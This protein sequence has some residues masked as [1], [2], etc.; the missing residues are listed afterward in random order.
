V[1]W[2]HLL[3]KNAEQVAKAHYLM[4]AYLCTYGLYLAIM[5][6]IHTPGVV[7]K[8]DSMLTN[9]VVLLLL[10]D[11]LFHIVLGMLM[12]GWSFP[13]PILTRQEILLLFTPWTLFVA[14]VIVNDFC[15]FLEGTTSFN[16]GFLASVRVGAF[17]L[18][19]LVLLAFCNVMWYT[20][21]RAEATGNNQARKFVLRLP[22]YWAFYVV[23]S[24]VADV[25]TSRAPDWLGLF[26]G[27]LVRI[28]FMWRVGH[29]FYPN[30]CFVYTALE[31]DETLGTAELQHMTM[32]AG[33]DIGEDLER[34]SNGRETK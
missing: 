16:L 19:F 22:R 20:S 11:I 29:L 31:G 12:I 34:G 5:G 33:A 3:K 6:L 10:S 17:C 14:T 1:F 13:Q 7:S 25:I 15:F 2:I 21:K 4:S 30:R 18:G 23:F 24:L 9:A 27:E 28:G 8:P 26:A 32:A